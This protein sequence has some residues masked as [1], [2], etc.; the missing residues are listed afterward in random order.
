M[1]EQEVTPVAAAASA[2]ATATPPEQAARPPRPASTPKAPRQWLGGLALLLTLAAIGGGGYYQWQRQQSDQLVIDH[3]ASE[4]KQLRDQQPA[5]LEN[6]RQRQQQVQNLSTSQQQLADKQQSLEKQLLRLDSRQPNDWLLA[7]ADYLVRMAGRKLWLEH[8]ANAAQLLLADADNRL[9]QLDDPTLVPLREA[10]ANDQAKLKA[11]P[12]I[13]R[14]GLVL[15]LGALIDNVDQLTLTGLQAAPV[16][17]DASDQPP[18]GELS[19]WRSNLLRTWNGFVDHF[20]TIRRRDGQVEALLSPQQDWYLKEN[21][22]T[23]L[24]Q[25]QLAVFREQ[26]PIYE[27]NLNKADKWIEQYFDANDATT[28]Y[29]HSEI[30]RLLEQPLAVDLPKQFQSQATLESLVQQRL[31]RLLKP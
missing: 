12:Q 17:G 15:R 23:R 22:K 6:D 4:I 25:A 29:M 8:D 27:D 18:S 16:A 21:L 26:P 7:E 20:I 9:R 31:Q 5:V 13:D 14:E 2:A 11:L 30:A 1:S 24:L 3:L 19:E 28:Q 10:L